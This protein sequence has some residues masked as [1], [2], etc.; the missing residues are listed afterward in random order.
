MV[1][2]RHD[3]VDKA[4]AEIFSD[5]MDHGCAYNEASYTLFGYILLRSDSDTPERMLYP[6]ARQALKGW[7]TRFPQS[8]RTGA[9]P[10][11][12]YVLANKIAESNPP[13]AAALLLQLDTYARPSEIVNLKFGDVVRPSSK[14]CKFWGI[15]FGNSSFQETTKTGT[16]DDTVLLTSSD[17]PFAKDVLSWVVRKRGAPHQRLFPGFTLSEYERALRKAKSEVGLGLFELTPHTVR[18]AG[19]SA[20]FLSQNRSAAE[21]QARGRWKT[22]KSIQRYQKPGQMMAKMNKIPD[23]IWESAKTALPLVLRKISRHYGASAR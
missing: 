12:W 15:I 5:L 20:D 21:I 10:L 7:N 8:S 4:L 11:V 18:H 23:H 2:S 9:D 1:L 6:R 22:A 16:Q 13:C 19:P 14:H 17:R 3:K